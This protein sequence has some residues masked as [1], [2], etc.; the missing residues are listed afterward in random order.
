[1]LSSSIAEMNFHEGPLLQALGDEELTFQ[2]IKTADI[3]KN[4]GS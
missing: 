4:L 2:S 1:M 3:H